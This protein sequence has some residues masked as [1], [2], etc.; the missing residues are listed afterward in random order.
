MKAVC[1]LT[2][3][4][5][6]MLLG[7][8]LWAANDKP[9]SVPDPMKLQAGWWQY[10]DNAG[11]KLPAKA[12]ILSDYLNKYKTSENLPEERI[13]KII[14][15]INVYVHLLKQTTQVTT[16]LSFKSRESCRLDEL[17][18]LH[19]IQ[20]ELE[21]EIALQKAGLRQFKSSISSASDSLSRRKSTYLSIPADDNNKNLRGLE[22]IKS[23]IYLEI[24]R[25]R[26]QLEQRQLA[27]NKKDLSS[28]SREIDLAIEHLKSD[29]T[30]INS[31]KAAYTKAKKAAEDRSKRLN[32]MFLKPVTTEANT[33]AAKSRTRHYSQQVIHLGVESRQASLRETFNQFG[34][35]VLQIIENPGAFDFKSARQKLTKNEK[36]LE[37]LE[38]W[39]SQRMELT[40]HER[41][42]A[43]SLLNSIEPDQII[44]NNLVR[45]RLSLAA[46]TSNAISNL[47]DT[48]QDTRFLAAVLSQQME[49][50]QGGVESLIS[51]GEQVFS[52]IW[53]KLY[54]VFTTP[55]FE[56]NHKPITATGIVIFFLILFISWVVSRWLRKTLMAY[57]QK[58]QSVDTAM[59]FTLSRIFHY[60]ILLV[61]FF[62][63]ISTLNIN[64]SDFA[65]IAGALGVGVG[66]GLQTIVNNF[67]SGLVLL[68]EKTLKRGDFVELESGVFGEV[69]SINMRSTV[70]TT[71]DNVD[72]VVPNA[73]FVGGRVTNWTMRETA[74]RF[75]IP[76]GVAY[77]TALQAT[78]EAVLQAT[79]KIP[80]TLSNFA[81]RE[82]QV[83]LV[84]LGD[85][86]LNFELVVW[87][88]TRA[89]KSPAK[90]KAAYLWQ[91]HEALIQNNIEIPFPQRDIHIRSGSDNPDKYRGAQ[92][93]K[94]R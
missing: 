46:K 25:R 16:H 17:I 49:N 90:I 77:G 66:F 71:P 34:L 68:F 26:Q 39:L 92:N 70:I 91:I 36:S 22:W 52:Q 30:E 48:A 55:L 7:L 43:H 2:I 37:Q 81:G 3:L 86:S 38:D 94:G 85:S 73:E 5:F 35:L 42:A 51:T 13:N 64:L 41:N 10:F 18:A 58:Y 15:A 69:Q 62:I 27:I 80:Y 50:S 12:Q 61:G 19:H 76:F 47:K 24:N 45:K 44:L 9:E 6:T 54:I 56:I 1:F 88:R 33:T 72:I 28:V 82:P 32:R 79:E 83:W 31:W 23:R 75:H 21:T 20:L 67:I 57:A 65:L 59:A 8:P 11:D 60:L 87:I 78:E 4:A 53:N 74:R 84:E 93:S 89:V 63:A 14:D 29:K 40:I